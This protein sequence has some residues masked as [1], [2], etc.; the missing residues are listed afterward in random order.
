MSPYGAEYLNRI[1][2]RTQIAGKSPRVGFIDVFRSLFLANSGA[3]FALETYRT[4]EKEHVPN[5]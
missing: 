2:G 3:E 5:A 4:H 1:D